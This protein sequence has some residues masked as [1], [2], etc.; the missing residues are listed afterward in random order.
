M[1]ERVQRDGATARTFSIADREEIRINGRHG[2]ED[3][4]R[5]LI[6]I[7]TDEA[8]NWADRPDRAER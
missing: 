1:W 7:D 5:D 8:A 3:N 4:D 6:E 2:L